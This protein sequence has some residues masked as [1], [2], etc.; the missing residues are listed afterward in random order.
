MRA[1]RRKKAP[2]APSTCS[3]SPV[4]RRRGL[5]DRGQRIGGAR[6]R[7][8]CM[9]DDD[10]REHA[11]RSVALDRRRRARRDR[12]G[13]R[14]RPRRAHAVGAEPER[15]QRLDVREVQLRAAV[16]GE[17]RQRADPAA[18]LTS[19]PSGLPDLVARD[20][21]RD[22]VRARRAARED[23]AAAR[24]RRAGRRASRARPARARVAAGPERPE[25][26]VLVDRRRPRVRDRR[27]GE[28]AAGDVAEVA[29]AGRARRAPAATRSTSSPRTPLDRRARARAAA[30][31]S[32]ARTAAASRSTP[33]RAGSLERGPEPR[34]EVGD[35]GVERGRAGG[36]S[37]VAVPHVRSEPL[38]VEAADPEP[39]PLGLNPVGMERQELR[40]R[41][42]RPPRPP[43]RPASTVR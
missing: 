11:L 13:T 1:Q 41:A 36:T 40:A 23:R 19:T 33:A 27:G 16:D 35:G 24:K 8:S 15:A 25:P 32:D 14:R 29:P 18:R 3:Q 2:K 42:P 39:D 31:S 5:G 43:L 30:P 38:R 12:G 9:G 17:R 28:D 21:E 7:R 20:G 4:L 6:V 22:E 34:R 37:I 26:G 10:R